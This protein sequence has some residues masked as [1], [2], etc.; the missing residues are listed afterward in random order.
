MISYVL[1]RASCKKT[2]TIIYA[3]LSPT[4]LFLHCH[5]LEVYTVTVIALL[6]K[7]C[8]RAIQV[9]ASVAG[10]VLQTNVQL[11]LSPSSLGH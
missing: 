1:K 4:F 8:K 2:T 7:Q 9:A 6:A 5:P 3:L 10:C 11:P